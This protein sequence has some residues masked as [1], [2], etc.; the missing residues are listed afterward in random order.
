MRRFFRW[1]AV[2]ALPLFLLTFSPQGAQAQTGELLNSG[3]FEWP[4]NPDQRGDGGG[5]IATGW[6]AW[7]Y[8]DPGDLYDGPEYKAASI[9]VDPYRVRSGLAA[10]QYFRAWARH[11]GGLY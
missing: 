10:Q 1:A 9:E 5:F 3:G 6:S 11:Q 2:S 4:Y 8:N 7:W